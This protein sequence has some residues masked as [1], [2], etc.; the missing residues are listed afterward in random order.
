VRDHRQP[1]PPVRGFDDLGRSRVMGVLN[2]T[3]DSFSDGGTFADPADAVRAGLAMLADGADLIDVGGES[4]RPGAGRVEPA[5]ERRRVVPVVAELA[6]AGAVVS[7]DTT[8]ASVAEAALDAGARLV[9][10]VSGATEPDL[11]ELVARRGVPYVLMHAR[12][13]SAGMNSRA[14]YADVVPEVVAEVVERLGAV[15]DAGIERDVVIVDPG[16][17]F[18]KNA[19]HNWALLSRLDEL[20]ALGRPLLVGTS[21]KSFLG[22]LLAGPDGGPRPVGD[23]EDATQA[24]T[25]LAAPAGVWAVRVHTVR[26]ASDAVRVARAWAT[27]EVP[28]EPAP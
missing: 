24:T 10:D 7:V 21:R 11:L 4:T 6:A 28:K 18:A 26:P 22:R 2:V 19:G 23:R 27:G 12:G 25:A 3:P 5:E 16:I 1:A 14:V 15:L 8:R 9:N 17:G 20:A 13:T